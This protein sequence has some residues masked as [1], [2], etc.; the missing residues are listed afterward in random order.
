ML[1]PL[2]TRVSSGAACVVLLWLRV[3][4]RPAATP[5]WAQD[6]CIHVCGCSCHPTAGSHSPRHPRG[7]VS[8]AR[9][10]LTCSSPW[11]PGFSHGH[12]LSPFT[13]DGCCLLTSKLL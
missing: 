6:P 11:C 2:S 9:G 3:M 13:L 4:G 5:L 1:G 10:A 7:C 8:G 12:S